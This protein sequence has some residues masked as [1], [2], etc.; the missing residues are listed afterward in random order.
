VSQSEIKIILTTFELSVVFEAA[1][2]VV[3][4]GLSMKPNNHKQ[5]QF[6]QIC[7]TLFGF[8]S[9]VTDSTR[10]AK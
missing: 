10:N 3:K 4:I 2:T 5:I 9:M 1:R 6:L 8:R 7:E